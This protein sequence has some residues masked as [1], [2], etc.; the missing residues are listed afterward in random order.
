[1]KLIR[2]LLF[3]R[4]LQCWGGAGRA[5]GGDVYAGQLGTALPSAG[6]R[7]GSMGAAN[8]PVLF[9]DEPEVVAL[10]AG[11]F[12]TC[13]LFRVSNAT[14]TD[15][16]SVRCFGHGV[17]SHAPSSPSL[18][19]VGGATGGTGAPRSHS[20]STAP[21]FSKNG[22]A[23]GS[24]TPFGVKIDTTEGRRLFALSG[25]LKKVKTM[26]AQCENNPDEGNKAWAKRVE[27]GIPQVQ[28]KCVELRKIML[29]VRLS[30]LSLSLPPLCL[31]S[32][33][34]P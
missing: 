9:N 15:Q 30:L 7:F 3:A 10:A 32:T 33:V 17:P 21:I 16:T 24:R 12:R 25:Q 2:G 14:G 19:G 29:Q 8:V 11:L 18:L 6:Q 26:L 22:G 27:D 13:G 31:P 20:L 5:V 23:W 1:M 34:R 28:H 4:L